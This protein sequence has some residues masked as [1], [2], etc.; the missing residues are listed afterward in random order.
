M[1]PVVIYTTPF[2]PYCL[3]AKRLLSKKGAAFEEI[4]VGGD[5][6]AREALVEKSGGRMTVPQISH[7][8]GSDDLHAL[9]RAGKLDAL[10]AD[11][12]GK[13][14]AR[15]SGGGALAV[16]RML[17]PKADCQSVPA[18]DYRHADRQGEQFI[19][20][21]DALC[22]LVIRIRRVA[23]SDPRQRLGPGE[24]S[25]FALGVEFRFMP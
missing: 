10:F 21:E 15:A 20:G 3:M 2:C 5:W 1:K 22:S 11:S 16:R 4:D 19:F 14:R 23:L 9:D 24:S 25:P 8:G 17:Q 18:I 12:P 7:V 13:L 6:E